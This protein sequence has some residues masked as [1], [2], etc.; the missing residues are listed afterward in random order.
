MEGREGENHLFGKNQRS[1]RRGEDEREETSG[2]I[3]KR[4]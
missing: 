2:Q 4:P 3:M 1:E